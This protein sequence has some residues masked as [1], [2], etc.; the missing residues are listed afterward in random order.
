MR[1]RL[2]SLREKWGGGRRTTKDNEG[3][4]EL[5]NY[6]FL[7]SRPSKQSTQEKKVTESKQCFCRRRWKTSG[8]PRIAR[9]IHFLVM[10]ISLF[11][12]W[13][14]EGDVERSKHENFHLSH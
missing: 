6:L 3:N 4:H 2:S 1:A 13:K 8:N 9:N 5:K 7:V 12:S 11:I 10:G 14:S